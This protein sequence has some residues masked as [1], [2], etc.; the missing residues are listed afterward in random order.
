MRFTLDFALLSSVK[1]RQAA[2]LHEIQDWKT[3]SIFPRIEIFS[4]EISQK[5]RRN[6][7]K[8]CRT[9]HELRVKNFV[10]TF[11]KKRES[12]NLKIGFSI[13]SSS[14][15]EISGFLCDFSQW[16]IDSAEAVGRSEKLRKVTCQIFAQIFQFSSFFDLP[17]SSW[18]TSSSLTW[19]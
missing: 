6:V 14:L 5:A 1:C 19:H 4:F 2:N 16:K 12:Q 11:T 7:S 18:I 17:S 9:Q 10:Y 8:K 15:D 13:V 3:F